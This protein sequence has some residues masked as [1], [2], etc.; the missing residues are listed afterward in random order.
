VPLLAREFRALSKLSIPL[1]A[2]HLA[3]MLLWVVDLMMIGHVG[4]EELD[5]VALG[6]LWIMGTLIFAMGVVMGVD[7]LV[8]QAHGARDEKRL[9]LT[10][11]RGMVV[12]LMISI[13]TAAAWLF[14]EEFL[15][16]TGQQPALSALAETYVLAQLGGIPFFLLFTVLRQYLIGRGITAPAMWVAFLANG[17][18]V[19]ANWALIFG[20]LGM[21]RM[22]VVGAALATM[23]TQVFMATVLGAWIF[24]AH[25]NRGA[26]SG[27]TRTAWRA[28]GVFEILRFGF[29]IGVTISLEFWAFL[30][31]NLLAGWL[32]VNALASH[33]IVINLASIAFMVPMGISFGVVT[34]VGNLIGEGDPSGAQRAAWVGFALG[35]G[36]MSISAAA[37]VF[38]RRFLPSLYTSDPAIIATC[39]ALLPIA[40]AF[41][42]FDGV[43]VVGGGILRGMGRTRPAAVINL[44]GYYVLALPAAYWL[45]FP[46]GYGLPG[47]WW[48]LAF[49]LAVIATALVVWVWLRGPARVDARVAAS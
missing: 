7:P 44:I 40:A 2:A 29:P 21:P 4:V 47:M 22:G 10:L 24:A 32:G 20:N 45:G 33:T 49:G 13:P 12:S 37:F 26:W 36:V 16:L 34:R 27:W 30:W 18:N 11:Q 41:Q 5:A 46:R 8:A 35:G 23:L 6:R 19:V 17:V 1:I 31:A 48:G 38:G 42:L 9:G 3:T 28:K 15:L 14:T 39:A 43:Q 25:L